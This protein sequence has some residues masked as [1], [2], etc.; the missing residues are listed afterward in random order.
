MEIA[1][2]NLHQDSFAQSLH[3]SFQECGFAVICKHG[4]D[5]ELIKNVYKEWV[6]FFGLSEEQKH[7]YKF[8]REFVNV[9]DGYFPA[10]ISETAKGY[11]FKDLKEF[12]HYSPGGDKLPVE[13]KYTA[14]LYECLM[15][16]AKKLTAALDS[17]LHKENCLPKN[18]SLNKI[19]DDKFGTIMRIIHYPKVPANAERGAMRAAAHKD[20]N[21]I[22]LLVAATEPGLAVQDKKEDWHLIDCNT[23]DIIVNCGDML[24]ELTN[25]FYKSTAHKVINPDNEGE[26][27]ARY[28]MPLFVHPEPKTVLSTK[29]TA[30]SFLRERLA[31]NGL[32]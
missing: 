12:F 6:D 31:E 32:I 13:V 20:I 2:I 10:S 7:M 3:R 26:N 16:V 19:I 29:Y 15:S 30:K 25:G 11:K 21:L 23:N 4:I 8:Q 5:S 28:S 17:I 27:V 1:K 14:E 24:Q 9:Q 18:L 22:T